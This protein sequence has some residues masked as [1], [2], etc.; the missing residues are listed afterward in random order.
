MNEEKINF[1][2]AREFSDIISDTFT[3]LKTEFKPLLK[4]VL[5]YVGPIILITSFFSSWYQSSLLNT[6]SSASTSNLD[7]I[8]DFYA[9]IFNYQYFAMLF[10]SMISSILL[11]LSVLSYIKLYIKHGSGNFE[12]SD[13][14]E[15]MKSKFLTVVLGYVLLFVAFV[16]GAS[17]I[18]VASLIS[19]SLV[20]IFVLL[21]IVAVIY[22]MVAI[23]LYIPAMVIEDLPLIDSF[24][25]SL[26][27]VKNYWWATLGVLFITGLIASIGQSILTFPQMV[28]NLSSFYASASGEA[29]SGGSS[30]LL[31][32]LNVVGT[33]ASYLLYSIPFTAIG[34]HYFSQIEKKENTDLINRIEQI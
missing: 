6:M 31:T 17:I 4:V 25:R 16:L 14:W 12:A 30:I 34:M 32:I 7:D 26:F 28:V 2:K 13:V 24:K 11:I 29:A 20:V 9:G 23:T 10:G 5:T 21:Y 15:V 3:F 33:F 1:L 8:L 18:G 27:L 19:T 22:F